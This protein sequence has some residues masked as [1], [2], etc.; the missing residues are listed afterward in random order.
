ML[1]VL[2]ACANG[3]GTSLMMKEKAQMALITLGIKL[4]VGQ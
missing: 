4:H 1:K 2:V 3:S